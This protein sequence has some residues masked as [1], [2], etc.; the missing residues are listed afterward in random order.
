M[1][2]L[3][4]VVAIFLYI[5]AGSNSVEAK[6]FCSTHSFFANVE[7]KDISIPVHFTTG[8]GFNHS[9]KSKK[10]PDKNKKRDKKG[11]QSLLFEVIG[12]ISY[13]LNNISTEEFLF[14]QLPYYFFTF[15]NNGKRGP[16]ACQIS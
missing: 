10:A 14:K 6:N 5:F 12:D 11:V 7:D 15:P 2:V 1:K 16:P 13:N 8:N 3:Y 9:V 4:S